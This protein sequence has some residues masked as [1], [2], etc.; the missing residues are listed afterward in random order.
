MPQNK[1]NKQPRPPNLLRGILLI[2][3]AITLAILAFTW[4]VINH[5]VEQLVA[6]RT[7]EYAHSIAKIAADSS[8]EPLLAND[9]LQL[10]LLT[11]N[12][13]KDPYIYQATVFSED[14]QIASQYPEDNDLVNIEDR[15]SDI[16][17][18]EFISRKKNI[19]FIEKINYQDITAGWFQLEI[20]RNKLEQD[21]RNEFIQIQFIIGSIALI[22]FSILILFVLKLEKQVK[23]LAWSC[24]HFLFQNRIKIPQNKP[25]WI[26]AVET[27]SKAHPQQLKTH[28][29]LPA[30]S[31]TWFTSRIM[32]NSLV[33]YLEFHP[34]T[35][36]DNNTPENMSLA[37]DYLNQA[38]Q[39]FG[40]HSQ[41]D[42]LTGCLI[43]IRSEEQTE[44]ADVFNALC[45]ISLIQNLM[46]HLEIQLQVKACLA[47]STIVSLENEHD[48]V[49]GIALTDDMLNQLRKY[50]YQTEYDDI[51]LISI[52]DE[53]VN[54]YAQ[55][56]KLKNLSK[57][58]Q[59]IGRVTQLTNDISTTIDRKIK[60]IINN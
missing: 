35:L 46:G 54:K 25:K 39:A 32:E 27:L 7:S 34:Q 52:P 48:M 14:G 55:T 51:L 58:R 10:N 6:K 41:G 19:P 9:K 38:I 59:D 12:I 20:E 22:L 36:E 50:L 47:I 45:L 60:Y 4:F 17:S 15:E 8:A 42:I 26:E 18:A 1:N 28:I 24:Q 13:A 23:R 30:K 5:Q 53:I 57:N 16:S 40:L 21:F 3:L 56:E 44:S 49:T 33:C 31:D 29:N 43:P 2:T 37:E 11:Q